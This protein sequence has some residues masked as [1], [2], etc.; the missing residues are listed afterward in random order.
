MTRGT[1][2]TQCQQS[3]ELYIVQSRNCTFLCTLL[4]ETGG[5]T[6][7]DSHVGIK[8]LHLKIEWEFP[9]GLVG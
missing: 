8:I 6:C 4:L 9:C 7:V 1:D 2:P 3:R 5:F